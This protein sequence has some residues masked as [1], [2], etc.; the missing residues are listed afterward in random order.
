MKTLG[1]IRAGFFLSDLLLGSDRLSE[2]ERGR[3]QT[4]FREIVRQRGFPLHTASF[5][6]CLYFGWDLDEQGYLGRGLRLTL[7]QSGP[8]IPVGAIVEVQCGKRILWAEVVYKEG[9]DPG[10]DR[11]LGVAEPAVSGT[12]IKI[13][14]SLTNVRLH[15]ALVLDFNAFGDDFNDC[16]TT[17]DRAARKGWLTSDRHLEVDADYGHA[18]ADEL[19]LFA[20]HVMDEYG[21]ELFNEALRDGGAGVTRDERWQLLLSSLQAVEELAVSTPG[22]QTFGHYHL[23]S[24]AYQARLRSNDGLFGHEGLMTVARGL[25]GPGSRRKAY[26]AAGPLVHEYLARGGGIDASEQELLDGP[27]YARLVLEA[28]A[29]AAGLVGES[30]FVDGAYARLDDEYQGGGVWRAITVDGDRPTESAWNP[31]VPLGL[32]YAETAA[33]LVRLVPP[34]DDPEPPMFEAS[35]KGWRVALRLVDLDRRELPLPP[36]AMAMLDP[37]ATEVLV[38]FDDGLGNKYPRKVRPVDRDR[39]VIGQMLFGATL[40]SG[41]YLRCAVSFGG[42]MVSV[43]TTVLPVPAKIGNRLLPLDF[44]EPTYRREILHERLEHPTV[45]R[46]RTLKDQIAAIFRLRGRQMPEG[47]LALTSTEVAS[48]ILGPSFDPDI[49]KPITLALQSGGC[50]YRDG[51]YVWQPQVDRQT[52]PQERQRII[53]LRASAQGARLASHLLK[54]QVPMHLRR[55]NPS[56]GKV[57]S[58]ARSRLEFHATRLPEKLPPGRT[59][60][61]PFEIGG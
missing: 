37:D 33:D 57:S 8:P 39:R 26:T 42:R 25:V 4:F 10:I 38:D 46:A 5:W 6:N 9:R 36:A 24:N 17:F 47:G 7:A 31:L 59:W 16:D 2:A 15:E 12:R 30:G 21:S 48:A 18:D 45:T 55:R 52:S 50:A 27:G 51:M 53:A 61:R 58:Y 23:D 60:V 32:G 11:E 40:Y 56:P 22:L 35:D 44:N 43:H 49:A 54:R 19:L 1:E 41:V 29:T 28:N 13:A 34:C 20:R 3:Y 14:R